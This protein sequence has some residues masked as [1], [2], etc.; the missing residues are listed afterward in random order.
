PATLRDLS[1]FPTR[2]SS[3]LDSQSGTPLGDCLQFTSYHV[4]DPSLLNAV[5]KRLETI[6]SKYDLAQHLSVEAAGAYVFAGGSAS[7]KAALDRKSTRLNSS[8]EWISYA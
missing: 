1:S 2:R 7:G 8:H 6:S 5:S 4:G 3:D